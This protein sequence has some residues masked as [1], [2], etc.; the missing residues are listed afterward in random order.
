MTSLNEKQRKNGVVTASTG[1]HGAAVSLGMKILGINGS[2]I[3]PENIAPNK[4]ENIKNL[5]GTVEYYGNDCLEAEQR[6]QEISVT[7]GAIYISPYNDPVIVAGQGTMG[8]EL[9]KDLSNIDTVIVAVGGGGLISGIGGYL[10]TVQPK[11]KIV[12]CSPKNS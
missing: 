1:N 3:V 4:V 10:K 2:I 7:T 6:A 9:D 11:V 12:G 8:V 5:G